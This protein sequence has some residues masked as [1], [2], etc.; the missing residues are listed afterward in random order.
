MKRFLCPLLALALLAGCSAPG[1]LPAAT[2]ETA[3]APTPAPQQ[4]TVYY[5]AGPESPAGAA[6]RAY[7][8]AQGVELTELGPQ[9]DPAAADLAV[10]QAEPAADGSWLNLREDTL[11]ATAAARGGLTREDGLAAD[12]VY[13]LPLGK[14]LY[15]YW[16]D[17]ALLAALLGGGQDA[18]T[19]D[20]QA[21]SW[22]EWSSLVETL[23]DWLAEPAETTVTL[24]G[25]DYA[26]PAERPAEAA[27][28]TGVFSLCAE[29][30]TA[31]G[32]SLPLYTSALLAAGAT[33]SEDTLT[34]PL[35]GVYS[36]LTLELENAAGAESQAAAA[37]AVA[38]GTALFY[39]GSLAG[40]RQYTGSALAES[41]VWLPVKCDLVQSDLGDTEYN[42]TGL[43]NY[44]VLAGE[45]W[46]AIPAGASEQGRQAAAAAMLWLYTSQAGEETLT[47][48]LG[49]VTPW[50]T[51]SDD[52][53]LAA[54]Q[55]EQVGAGILPQPVPNTAQAAALAE[56]G[57]AL[58]YTEDGAA[59]ESFGSAV[60]TAWREAAVQ[61]LA[62]P[63]AAD[64]QAG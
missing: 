22:E 24:N 58:L 7:A 53:P 4:L 13:A 12:T 25:R 17:G 46:L 50:G 28:L 27:G 31:G 61:A 8:A 52:D 62:E 16:A 54:M 57:R 51:A 10:L 20:L 35:N 9:D 47:Q 15:A 63:E 19:A 41:L 36:A 59:R 37:Q 64:A 26:L 30:M 14:A 40:W 39:R 33:R 29:P 2:A 23:T 32:G 42:L 60:R 3:A 21:A 48:T 5:A 1:T 18:V 43:L 49:L 11:L 6:L 56:A 44:P 34:G 38:G 55:V 45:A